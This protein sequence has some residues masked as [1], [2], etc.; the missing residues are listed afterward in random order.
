MIS[1]K[2]TTKWTQL[3]LDICGLTSATLLKNTAEKSNKIKCFNQFQIV[4]SLSKYNNNINHRILG[5]RATHK[6]FMLGSVPGLKL[7]DVAGLGLL[8]VAGLGLLDV[9]GL[10]LLDADG[11]TASTDFFDGELVFDGIT[12]VSGVAVTRLLLPTFFFFLLSPCAFNANFFFFAGTTATAT[13][14][15]SSFIA[16]DSR[17]VEIGC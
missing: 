16:F 14:S 11:T 17:W 3:H 4:S 12:D 6:Q 2:K 1:F 5:G 13:A 8:D 10:G 15:A 7:L 9:A